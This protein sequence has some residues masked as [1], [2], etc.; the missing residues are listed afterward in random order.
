MTFR[1]RVG[2]RRLAI[3]AALALPTAAVSAGAQ[4][5]DSAALATPAAAARPA[6]DRFLT[7]RDL[8]VAA[9]LAA[10]I[11]AVAPF[12]ARI[13]RALEAPRL[14]RSAA[15]RRSALVFDAYGA[16]GAMIAGPALVVAGSLFRSP[17]ATDVGLHVSESYAA[18]MAV[19]LAAKG[20]AGRARPNAWERRTYDFGFGRG[21]PHR[22]QYSSFPSGH[23]TGSFAFAA[24]IASEAGAHWPAHARTVGALAYGGAALDGVSRVYRDS[25]WASDVAAGALVG[26]M[27]GLL[28]TRFQH[29]HPGN[30]LDALARRVTLAPSGEGLRLSVSTRR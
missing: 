1:T 10:T 24:A 15:W 18:A 2:P 17:V 23:A 14:H 13:T 8:G 3:A 11:A 12:D 21:Y 20:V 7:R 4:A 29:A 25:H 9:G 28:V 26:T 30:R 5:T 27:S 6:G 16:P 22:Q 19:T